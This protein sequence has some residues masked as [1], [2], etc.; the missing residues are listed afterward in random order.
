VRASAARDPIGRRGTGRAGLASGG[1]LLVV[2]LAGCAETDTGDDLAGEW[3]EA[4]SE[5]VLTL[6]ADGAFS[7]DGASGTWS[8]HDGELVIEV[9]RG[10]LAYGDREAPED[11]RL[12]GPYR[13]EDDELGYLE[14]R[15]E[16]RS[17]APEADA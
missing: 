17:P 2:A 14:L 3:V 13:L 5:R 6:S 16:R 9:E 8:V 11:F 1:L 7:S 4:G 10:T 15:Y 12:S